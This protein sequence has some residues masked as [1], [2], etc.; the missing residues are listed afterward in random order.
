MS[1]FCPPAPSVAAGSL[2]R[3]GINYIAAV[4]QRAGIGR[5]TRELVRALV[6]EL[7][8]EPAV[9]RPDLRLLVPA[10]PALPRP[11]LPPPARFCR[12]PLTEWQ[13]AVF[14]QRLRIPLPASL[15]TGPL[16]VFHEPDFLL[17]PVRAGRRIVTV[18]DLSYQIHPELAHPAMYRLLIQ[19]VP[20]SVARA[21]VIIAVSE[22]TRRDLI[23]LLGVPADR[24]V[25]IAEGVDPAFR[26]DADPADAAARSRLGLPPRYLLTVG[27][28]QPRK[29]YNRLLTACERIWRA[30]P[31]APDLV[32]AGQKG[33]LYEDFFRRLEHSPQR[34]R[35][36][37][38]DFVADQD[39][40]ALYR[41]AEVFVYPSL[42]EGFGL[43]P[44]EAL[45]C[46]TAVVCSD[47][48]SLP[49]V[50]GDAARLVD[51]LDAG[52]LADALHDL[53][54]HPAGR[55]D[56]AAR[57]PGQAARFTWPEAARRHLAVYRGQSPVPRTVPDQATS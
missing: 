46:A 16:D 56:L 40:P 57:G 49:E 2:R 22:S 44:L 36:H 1:G 50:V 6:D 28:I 29:N 51:P 54:A 23:A 31:G 55:A 17:P 19:A 45:A 32:I 34:N 38:L 53:I 3:L 41:G 25:V 33:W 42:Y 8:A 21:D 35:V 26:P 48:S 18:H 39:L 37:V 14:W 4:S 12:L 43:P 30:D 11:D 20:R 47:G 9:D 5:Y 13:A 15:F 24:V 7:A 10:R 52:A 27:T